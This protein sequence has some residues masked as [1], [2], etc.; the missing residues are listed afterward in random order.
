MKVIKS[1]DRVGYL[2]Q[3]KSKANIEC[4]ICPNCGEINDTIYYL[5]KGVANKGIMS[6]LCKTWAKGFF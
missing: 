2:E 1:G 6:G 3:E 5:H 4:S